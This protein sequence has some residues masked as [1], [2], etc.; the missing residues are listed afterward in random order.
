[1]KVENGYYIW[2]KGENEKLSPYFSTK[3]FEC[4]CSLCNEQR[5]SVNIVNKLTDLR[6]ISQSEIYVNSAFRCPEH[7]AAIGKLGNNSH[8]DGNAVDI[9][10]KL[11][12]EKLVEFVESIFSN[13]GVGKSFVHVDVKVEPKNRWFYDF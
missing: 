4:P 6:I 2:K 7:N 8:L 1:M 13:I 11:M 10:S 12:V 3:D 5:I 9:R